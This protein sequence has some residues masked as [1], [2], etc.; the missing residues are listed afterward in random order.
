MVSLLLNQADFPTFRPARSNLGGTRPWV[1]RILPPEQAAE[2]AGTAGRPRPA[3]VH[4][5]APPRGS[6]PSSRRAKLL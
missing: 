5:S 2:S 1:V 6:R 3:H 4:D